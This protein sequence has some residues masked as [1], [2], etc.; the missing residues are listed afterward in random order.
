MVV[1]HYVLIRI[2]HVY[3]RFEYL[4]LLLRKSRALHSAYQFLGLAREHRAAYY[5]NATLMMSLAVYVVYC[6]HTY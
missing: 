2:S 5:L 1:A 3:G 4:N 6:C